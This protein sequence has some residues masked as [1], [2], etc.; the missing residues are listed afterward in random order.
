MRL[1]FL[2]ACILTCVG[3]WASAQSVTLESIDVQSV[4]GIEVLVAASSDNAMESRFGHGLIR[5]VGDH[6][7]P[8]NDIVLSFE[9]EVPGNVTRSA[10]IFNG[11][12]G[13]Y[14]TVVKQIH[15]V[16]VLILYSQQMNRGFVRIPLRLTKEQT[17]SFVIAL[18][19]LWARK[20]EMPA[21]TFADF[22][23]ARATTWLF[24]QA[25]IKMVSDALIPTQ[26]PTQLQMSL[27]A[28]WG[29]HH[30][31]SGA[32]AM[33]KIKTKE[34]ASGEISIVPAT[35]SRLTDSETYVLSMGNYRFDRE[36]RAL[37][38]ERLKNFDMPVEQ[39]YNLIHL[40]PYQYISGDR[41]KSELTHRLKS[42]DAKTKA[43]LNKFLLVPS[44]QLEQTVQYGRRNMP[45]KYRE[46]LN[47]CRNCD[48]TNII[49][50][51]E[52]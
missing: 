14:K 3:P 43:N 52:I 18:Q 44:M 47:E 9:A 22:N 26:L 5:L 20:I 29:T 28:P 24:V 21:Y 32:S 51:K 16:D 8:L 1:Y 12:T 34:T 36:S 10:L 37:M 40:E 49:N 11:M 23:C 4:N 25:G 2:L 38:S 46:I 27:L 42:L 31:P 39:V 15:L 33:K 35:L 13:G 41:S 30:M 6:S 45:E 48:L 7:D 50:T 19:K 17:R